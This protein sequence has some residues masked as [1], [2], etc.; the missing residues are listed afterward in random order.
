LTGAGGAAGLGVAG[1]V[2]LTVVGA[3][4]SAGTTGVLGTATAW[5]LV[6]VGSG[7]LVGALLVLV[8]A[9]ASDGNTGALG[10]GAV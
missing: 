6:T 8:G 3:G 4:A 2:L 10:A 9:G 5:V 7:G 1:G